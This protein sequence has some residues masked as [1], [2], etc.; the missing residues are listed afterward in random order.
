MKVL[1]HK[2]DVVSA[3][4][5]LL[6]FGGY[7]LVNQHGNGKGPFEDVFP[8]ENGDFPLL[9]M[10]ARGLVTTVFLSFENMKKRNEEPVLKVW[11][12][13]FFHI[14]QCYDSPQMMV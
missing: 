5:L 6:V 9:S 3:L 7:T 11:K 1:T 13:C 14:R 2:A 10:F 8:I 4:N 12:I